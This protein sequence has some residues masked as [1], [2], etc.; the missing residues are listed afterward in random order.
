M[1]PIQL[2]LSAFG[3][4]PGTETIDFERLGE[5]G[6]FVVSGPT[7]AGKTSVFDAMTFALY[8]E[9]PGARKEAKTLRSDH[10]DR[11]DLCSVTFS[12]E[13][14][15]D[16][17]Q[18]WR[19]P[20]Q[21][22]PKK[23]GD[24]TTQEKAKASLSRWISGGWQGLTTNISEV[25]QQVTDLVGLTPAQ[26][27]RV[28]LLP[29]GE[30]QRVLQAATKER[31]EL[32]RTLFAT[33][34][35][36]A[37][38]RRL[39]ENSKE[40]KK[41]LDALDAE[42][43]GEIGRAVRDLN[44]AAH[45][46]GID[47]VEHTEPAAISL[48]LDALTEGALAKLALERDNAK[49]V[50]RRALA[51]KQRAIESQAALTRKAQ[52]EATQQELSA[53]AP[54]AEW[55]KNLAEFARK[56]LSVVEAEHSLGHA[57]TELAEIT[58]RLDL[59]MDRLPASYRPDRLNTESLTNLRL[60]LQAEQSQ[61]KQWLAQANQAQSIATSISAD[62]AIRN[63]LGST[64]AQTTIALELLTGHSADRAARR[65]ELLLV[66]HSLDE[67]ETKATNLGKLKDLRVELNRLETEQTRRNHQL[68][69]LADSKADAQIQIKRLNGLALASTR[70]DHD[71]AS[72]IFANARQLQDQVL[73]DFT[74]SAAPTLAAQLVDGD[75]CPVCGSLEHPHK[76]EAGNVANSSIDDV[77][78]AQ[79]ATLAAAEAV[80]ALASDLD[81]LIGS[82][83]DVLT[84]A[85]TPGEQ[86]PD[87]SMSLKRAERVRTLIVSLEDQTEAM[88][89]DANHADATA[90]Q[91]RGQLGDWASEE[92]SILAD[93][94][95]A[96]QVAATEAIAA[97]GDLKRLAQQALEE[98]DQA[99]KLRALKTQAT[100]EQQELTALIAERSQQISQLKSDF[101]HLDCSV[102]ERVHQLSELGTATEAIAKILAQK[103]EV[104]G[105]IERAEAAVAKAVLSSPFE[106]LA[107]ASSAAV[108]LVEIVRLETKWETWN[109]QS[110]ETQV[111][112]KELGLNNL[113]D[114]PPDLDALSEDENAAAVGVDQ[115]ASAHAG[116]EAVIESGHNSLLEAE[117][118][119]AA[120]AHEREQAEAVYRLAEV[121]R[122][123]N[124]QKASLETWVL[125]SHLRDVIEKA[126]MHL[127]PMSSNR[128]HLQLSGSAGVSRRRET[129]LDLEIEDA[130]TSKTRP[131]NSLSGGETF[132]A[133]LALALGLADVISE[134]SSGVRLDAL[135]VDEGFGSLDADAL[136]H[137]I[138]VLDGLRDRGALVGVITHVEAVKEALTV[139]LQIERSPTG[140]SR[141]LQLV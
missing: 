94:H 79:A 57:R 11:H 112:L 30:F 8:G 35:F 98:Q 120:Y 102:S 93:A 139:G 6:L 28:M 82:L 128:Y 115:L 49:D 65:D 126:N 36:E 114:T 16:R 88:D 75:E 20:E 122:G 45:A 53:S 89:A 99:S 76:A 14:G 91:L 38:E 21:Q 109:R 97:G 48:A 116:I 3:P 80:Q 118:K 5:A 55:G 1:R 24:G 40:A 46:L 86:L 51:S 129:G 84:P 59:G 140:G 2:S 68:R 133:S 42:R 117:A 54:E 105:A 12:F 85:L 31:K 26:F 27:Q 69:E 41:T 111:A 81:N 121:C 33:D 141:L 56:A 15:A 37:A 52:V 113:P 107:V 87:A 44:Q 50:H 135:F 7:G 67:R 72:S 95:H 125:A 43:K 58:G 63:G 134:G 77:Q 39:A 4:Y 71:A 61:A 62:Q 10:A 108:P 32:L 47:P 132:Q 110:H 66:S 104:V 92:L 136:D 29:Q 74:A 13:A 90:A 64:L 25:T 70:A 123:D 106:S 18:V 73:S 101:S 22:R 137:A 119:S 9:L 83:G 34:A 138:D 19:Q 23:R 60:S 103:D 96:A 127:G 131:V 17:W 100:A 130:W 78:S 124:Q